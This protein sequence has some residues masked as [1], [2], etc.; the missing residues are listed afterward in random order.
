M[1]TAL[2]QSTSWPRFYNTTGPTFLRFLISRPH[3]LYSSLDVPHLGL[4]TA[5]ETAKKPILD[6]QFEPKETTLSGPKEGVHDNEDHTGGNT[7]AGGVNVLDFILMY[8]C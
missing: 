6:V 8:Y 3:H 4:E 1:F 5:R 7:F 2:K